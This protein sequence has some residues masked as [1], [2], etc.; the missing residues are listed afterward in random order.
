[1]H[2][3]RRLAQ[4]SHIK[5][6]NEDQ[7]T[8]TPPPS[9]DPAPNLNIQVSPW[10]PQK[11][12]RGKHRKDES[13]IKRQHQPP[14]PHEGPAPEWHHRH[15]QQRPEVKW[16]RTNKSPAVSHWEQPIRAQALPF[17]VTWLDK[18]CE[19]NVTE[20]LPSS[21]EQKYTQ[22]SAAYTNNTDPLWTARA[23]FDQFFS[24]WSGIS[25]K[26]GGFTLIGSLSQ[27]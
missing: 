27:F 11:P 8:Q 23:H 19:L 22:T 2:E 7:C 12:F 14:T 1:M 4:N 16:S 25:S 10:T 13:V 15:I 18:R 21:V 5:I 24:R 6:I 17:A 3:R 20:V 26:A 9:R